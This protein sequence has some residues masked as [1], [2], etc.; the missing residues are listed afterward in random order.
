[1]SKPRS[2]PTLDDVA[3]VAG[4]SRA[5]ASRA[6][7]GGHLV[8]ES[9]QQA[10]NAAIRELGYVPNLAARSLATKQS[11]TI[12]VVVSEGHQRIFSDPFFATAVSGIVERLEPTERHL[13]LHMAYGGYLSKLE[14]YL[15]GGNID[16]V[17]VV[18]HH[19]ADRL[20]ALLN[21]LRIP[22]AFLG[23]PLGG[24]DEGGDL[25]ISQ[26]YVDVDNVTGGRI[27]ARHLLECGC[28]KIATITGPMDIAS[29][30]ERLD[31][32][33]QALHEAGL[34]PVAVVEG[35]YD[36]ESARL[37]A[38]EL[39]A[40]G[41]EM[42]GLFVASDRMAVSAMTVLSGA[43]VR[44]PDDL[45]IMGFDNADICRMTTPALTSVTNPWRNL[46]IAATEMVLAQL[47]G[48][49]IS[50]PLIIS[51]AL[52]PRKSTVGT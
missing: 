16:A 21:E 25:A 20:P 18:S 36:T 41:V 31:G 46:A 35:D 50:G 4:V 32:F 19:E 17:I 10:I 23:R 26:H 24:M 51:P 27:A 12:A 3:R 34:E 7:R 47:N 15:R 29:A 13:A 43:G 39:L 28:T 30:R 44:I 14:D 1:M 11:N 6:I 2:S 5:T 37:R 8:S 9:A 49:K 33:T 40:M 42:D 52:V 45:R 22:C 48:E 38:R